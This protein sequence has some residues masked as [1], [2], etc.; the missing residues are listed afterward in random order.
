M[1]SLNNRIAIS[2][3]IAVGIDYFD[4]HCIRM[5]FQKCIFCHQSGLI[6]CRSTGINSNYHQMGI[7]FFPCLLIFFLKGDCR[8]VR[9]GRNVFAGIDQIIK[10]FRCKA[11]SFIVAFSVCCNRNWQDAKIL[12]L[13]LILCRNI[14]GRIGDKKDFFL[15]HIISSLFYSLVYL[16]PAQAMQLSF[17]LQCRKSPL[18]QR[19]IHCNCN[20]VGKIQASDRPNHR[21]TQTGIRVMK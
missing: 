15:I 3:C 12:Q 9:S 19:F 21:Q 11:F 8:N 1:T 13:L 16:I 7:T 4:S 18:T 6:H 20:R 10:F 17:V 5:L 14:T 2:H